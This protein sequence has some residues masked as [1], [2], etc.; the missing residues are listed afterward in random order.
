MTVRR[1]MRRGKA[2]MVALGFALVAGAMRSFHG[3]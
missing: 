1:R 2:V 3:V